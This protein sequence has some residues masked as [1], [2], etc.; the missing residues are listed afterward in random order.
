M[1]VQHHL[2]R[3]LLLCLSAASLSYPCAFAASSLSKKAKREFPWLKSEPGTAQPPNAR[4]G[5]SYQTDCKRRK[6]SRPA[7]EEQNIFVR[8][9]EDL[10]DFARKS[11]LL[12]EDEATIAALLETLCNT[13]P[14]VL[15]TSAKKIIPAQKAAHDICAN[16]G[17]DIVDVRLKQDL[18]TFSSLCNTYAS[19]C[20]QAMKVQ[21]FRL[22]P[23]PEPIVTTI[24]NHCQS[25]KD[26]DISPVEAQTLC[27][28]L[29]WYL[30]HIIF[31]DRA[32]PTL[33][34]DAI[35]A[36]RARMDKKPLIEDD[37]CRDGQ[38]EDAV[39]TTLS[40]Q[41]GTTPYLMPTA[42]YPPTS[43]LDN[44]GLSPLEGAESGGECKECDEYIDPEAFFADDHH[45]SFF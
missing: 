29:T 1:F 7:P 17:E 2:Q 15:C 28:H 12:P 40:I 19:L 32:L 23:L 18:S 20:Y 34:L 31:P 42:V 39:P 44:P 45:Q 38:G 10:G 25:L 3:W 27:N 5:P 36:Y 21:F 16:H 35:N 4:K 22:Y 33:I 13:L 11:F 24:N 43:R 37:Y 26:K 6:I 8:A 14:K 41:I 9:T 30:T